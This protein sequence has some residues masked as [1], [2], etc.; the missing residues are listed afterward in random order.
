MVLSPEHSP[1]PMRSREVDGASGVGG[2]APTPEHSPE[3]MR[4]REVD[5]ASGVGGGA[6][7][8]LSKSEP[9]AAA[10]GERPKR[11]AESR[12]ATRH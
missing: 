9:S 3:P 5:G 4:S 2:G 11:Q 12:G 10:Q 8:P 1:E 6:P 7:T